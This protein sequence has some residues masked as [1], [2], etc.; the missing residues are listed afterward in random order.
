LNIL[1]RYILRHYIRILLLCTAA[2][3]GIY[4]LIDFFEKIN[5]FVDHQA[6]A[7]IYLRY[8][9]SNVPLILTQIMPLA[10]L[11]ST[12]LTLGGLGRTNETTAMRASGVSF[13]KI[14][15][16]LIVMALL[17]SLLTACLSEYINPLCAKQLHTILEIELKG[18]KEGALVSYEIWYR[19]TNRIINITAA[20][21]SKQQLRGVKIFTLDQQQHIIKRIDADIC[22]FKDDHWI[23]Q[24]ATL[25]TF[26][27]ENGDLLKTEA[28]E[29][30][31]MTLNKQPSD[32]ASSEDPNAELNFSRL[33]DLVDKLESEGYTTTHQRVDMHNRLAT[34]F[35]CLIMGFLGV[36]FAL[37]RGR[38]SSIALGIGL[39][40]AVGV[41]Y[42]IVQ[43]LFTSF[44]YAGALPPIV[45]AWTA[46]LIF[47]LLGIWL[48]LNVKE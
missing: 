26:S 12:V 34:P 7:Q 47:L 18:K 4:L 39:S 28:K 23:A 14:V 10:V 13:W 44:G 3:V 41:V 48:Q 15:Q 38:G 40:V 42:F 24:V 20:D 43:S 8:F 16:P 5:D 35:S 37:Q 46:N 32:F 29:L 27:P 17:C 36:P 25:R 2:F 19:D 9:A 31:A 45:A 1:P 21:P 30:L 6:S 11:T 22:S 33:M